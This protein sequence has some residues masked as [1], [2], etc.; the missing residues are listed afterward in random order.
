MALFDR[1][2]ADNASTKV[3]DLGYGPFDHFFSVMRE[4]GFVQEAR[5]RGIEP[6][7]LFVTD[8]SERDSARLCRAA[9]AAWPRPSCRSTTNRS[10]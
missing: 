10:R 3:I 8:P 4:I 9:A 2:L 7:V 6:I 5:R 1:L